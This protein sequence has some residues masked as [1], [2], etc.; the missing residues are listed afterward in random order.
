MVEALSLF[1]N[2]SFA[3]L[4]AAQFLSLSAVYALNLNT[5]VL[6]ELETRSSLQTGVVILTI[7]VPGTIASLVA[8]PLV[9]RFNRRVTLVLAHLFKGTVA[10]LFFLALR[11]LKGFPLLLSAYL[12]NVFLSVLNQFISPAEAALLPALVRRRDLI[13]ANSVFQISSVVAQG[14]GALLLG[15][16]L[17]KFLGLQ[18]VPLVALVFSVIAAINAFLLPKGAHDPVTAAKMN[19]WEELKY[20]WEW[21]AKDRLTRT[22]VF[23]LSLTTLIMLSISTLLPGFIYRTMG[24]DASRFPLVV[25][26][27]GIGFVVGLLLLNRCSRFLVHEDW[28]C[29][30]LLGLG[31]SISAMALFGGKLPG[32]LSLSAMAC[33]AGM[34]LIFVPAKTLL[35]ERPP[36]NLRGRVF[37]TQYLVVNISSIGIMLF[38]GSMADFLGIRTV[39]FM[40]G[41]A[42][43]GGGMIRRRGSKKEPPESEAKPEG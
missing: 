23:Q 15:P 16:V 36:A 12:V 21:I 28:I 40:L 8:G 31:A 5:V 25:I 6:V 2:I 34:A 13:R 39:M 29:Y 3:R 32:F 17:I 22:A 4:L 20:G 37:S 1:K 24:W 7:T 43:L 41:L 27:V 33:G 42:A 35:Q 18:N 11:F 26:P 9:D 19:F 10:G 14:T 30:G 38:S